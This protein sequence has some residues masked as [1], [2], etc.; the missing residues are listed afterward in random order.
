LASLDEEASAR[1]LRRAKAAK[2]RRRSLVSWNTVKRDAAT[3]GTF[4]SSRYATARVKNC[5]GVSAVGMPSSLLNSVNGFLSPFGWQTPLATCGREI[6]TV[7]AGGIITVACTRK[8]SDSHDCEGII[9]SDDPIARMLTNGTGFAVSSC[10][11][12]SIMS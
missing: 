7:D 6:P 10:G 9:D 8:L 3:L 12:S 4:V 5:A 1:E 11:R 2:S